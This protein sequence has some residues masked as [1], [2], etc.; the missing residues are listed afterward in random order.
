M[1]KSLLKLLPTAIGKGEARV[2]ISGASVPDGYHAPEQ[3][4]K[5]LAISPRRQWLQMLWDYSSLPKSLYQQYYL[6]PLEHCVTLMQQFPATENG[7][8]AYL[9]GMVDHL[10][11]TVAY[12]ARLSKNYLLPVG[13]QPEDQASQSAAWNAVIVYAAMLQSLDM[14]C[15]IEVELESGQRWMPLGAMPDA[16]YRFRFKPVA[17]AIRVQSL[18]AMLAWKVIPDEVLIWL[19]TWPEVLNTLSLYLTGFRNESGIVNAIVSEAISTSIGK[20]EPAI[21]TTA[22]TP[23]VAP[24]TIMP[25]VNSSLQSA[26]SPEL[27]PSFL[28]GESPLPE[29]LAF[30]LDSAVPD[31]EAVKPAS[32]E[33]D[34]TGDLLAVMGFSDPT[35]LVQDAQALSMHTAIESGEDIAP[36]DP[37]GIGERFWRW[38]SEG[39]CSGDFAV[40]TV[41]ARIHIIAGY[42]F[43]RAPNIFHQ[44]LSENQGHSEDKTHLQNAFE[45]L[46]RHRQDK[47][48]MY[49]CHVY[50]DKAREGR[51]QKMTGYL[52]VAKKLYK[53]HNIPGDN[54]LVMIKP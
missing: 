3:A 9:G 38:L 14:L 18:G 40:N 11:E 51:F 19:S 35:N 7:H 8:H 46:G 29:G 17:D 13:A 26:S 16:P 2:A 24:E 32:P 27:V 6:Q 43:I 45:R 23:Q 31:S 53:G 37:E 15:H 28:P 44:F 10:L 30:S 22:S 4:A 49:T 41:D 12:A 25:L 48:V 33:E 5:L 42:V 20:G 52:I 1:L 21:A 54:P 50:Q 47:G 39:C 36:S 34:T